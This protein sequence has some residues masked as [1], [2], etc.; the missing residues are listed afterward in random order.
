MKRTLAFL[1]GVAVVASLGIVPGAEAAGGRRVQE[2]DQM[3]SLRAA[4]L[5]DRGVRD[6]GADLLG[7]DDRENVSLV[8]DSGLAIQ[9]QLLTADPLA[10]AKL[11]HFQRAQARKNIQFHGIRLGA[12]PEELAEASGGNPEILSALQQKLAHA[13]RGRN[14]LQVKALLPTEHHGR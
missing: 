14:N 1:A 10:A 4:T 5:A 11:S 2:R 12:T 8:R 9:G 13:Q 6:I 7:V 3:R